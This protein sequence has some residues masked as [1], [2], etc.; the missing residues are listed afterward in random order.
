MV[1]V[2]LGA[3]VFE[4]MDPDR[5]AGFKRGLDVGCGRT[6]VAGRGEMGT[7]VGQHGMDLVGHGRHE[8][9][10]EVGRDPAG[11]FLMPLSEGELGRAVDGDEE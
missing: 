5:L 6:R 2:V 4:G 9:A 7:V 8:G 1:D 3:S 11:G 10:P